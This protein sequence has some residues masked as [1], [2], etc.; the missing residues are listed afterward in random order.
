[1]ADATPTF[2][3][4]YGSCISSESRARTGL[5]GLCLPCT[6]S[7]FVRTW[8]ASIDL[9]KHSAMLVN[10]KVTGITAVSAQASAGGVCN[11]VIVQIDPSEL[12]RFDERE[13][14]YDRR[15]LPASAIKLLRPEQDAASFP[16]E[17]AQLWIYVH[18]EGSPTAAFPVPQTYLDVM[19]L[20]CCEYSEAFAEEFIRTTTGWGAEPSSFIDDRATPAYV[21]ASDEAKARAEDWDAMLQKHAPDALAARVVV[22]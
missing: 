11:G 10:P 15:S 12:P 14:G 17:T 4:F 19:L 18:P 20:G 9:T 7:G 3:F 6:V 5:S 13:A 8:S 2:V 21:R 1:M 16:V 22:G